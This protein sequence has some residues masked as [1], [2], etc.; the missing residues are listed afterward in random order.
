LALTPIFVYGTLLSGEPNHHLIAESVAWG[1]ARTAPHYELVDLGPYP[2][3]TSPGATEI[4]G[5][6]YLVSEATLGVLDVFE[7]HPTLYRRSRIVLSDG[8]EVFGYLMDRGKVA[9]ATV[10]IAGDWRGRPRSM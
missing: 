6:V 2:A 8:R 7:E 5:E 9:S 10:I 1:A 3:M 4:V